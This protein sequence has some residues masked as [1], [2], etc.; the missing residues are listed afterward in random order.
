MNILPQKNKD[1]LLTS[2]TATTESKA[3]KEEIKT[4]ALKVE[5]PSIRYLNLIDDTSPNYVLGYN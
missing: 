2:V 3:I 5:N 1:T 4:T